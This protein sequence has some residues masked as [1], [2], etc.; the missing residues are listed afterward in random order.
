M[1]LREKAW[2]MV[3]GVPCPFF[4]IEIAFFDHH[5][6]DDRARVGI[7][8]VHRCCPVSPSA[9]VS[10]P[11]PVPGWNGLFQ[12]ARVGKFKL[13]VGDL[14]VSLLRRSLPSMCQLEYHRIL[15]DFG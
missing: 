5:T 15:T 4:L 13:H 14:I 10:G 8:H 9:K 6:V 12:A 3:P 1:I 11:V 7:L 2:V